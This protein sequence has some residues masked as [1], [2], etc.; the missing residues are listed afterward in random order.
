MYTIIVEGKDLIAI[1]EDYE[2][3]KDA[4]SRI[5]ELLEVGYEKVVLNNH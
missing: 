2:S 1:T 5:V 3:L 4:T